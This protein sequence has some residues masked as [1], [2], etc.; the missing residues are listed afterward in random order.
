M[1]KNIRDVGQLFTY[2]VNWRKK[3]G[4][5]VFIRRPKI[6]MFSL[7]QILEKFVEG[8]Y[9]LHGSCRKIHVLL[10]HQ[11]DS[12]TQEIGNFKGV[13]A[14]GFPWE[15]LRHA[16]WSSCTQ[17]IRDDGFVSVSATEKIL[18]DAAQQADR[19]TYIYILRKAPFVRLANS[20][21]LILKAVVPDFVIESNHAECERLVG[22]KSLWAINRGN[23]SGMRKWF[24]SVR[25][26][27]LR[28][29]RMGSGEH[30]AEHAFG[31][32]NFGSILARQECPR[33]VKDVV[34][35]CFFHD[36]GRTDDRGG[37][38]HAVLGSDIARPIIKKH[39]KNLNLNK[40]LYAIKHHADGK[41]SR[42]KIVACIWDA[43]RLSLVRLG[44]KLDLAMMSTRTG[45][46][47]AENLNSVLEAAQQKAGRV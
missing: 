22:R 16:F 33:F 24:L 17:K 10:P 29:T 47:C 40:I 18:T 20:E 42:D 4:K 15:S 35:G 23:S 19:K 44:A 31:V 7:M 6:P 28:H 8:G 9:V 30:G 14:T 38:I 45:K 39:W 37:N 34:V 46:K 1:S 41:I 2:L 3:T 26:I 32:A 27:Y 11:A 36:I 25:A 5:C 13:Y 21:Y 12:K 43:D